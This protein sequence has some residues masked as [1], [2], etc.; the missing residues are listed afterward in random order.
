MWEKLN[1]DVCLLGGLWVKCGCIMCGDWFVYWYVFMLRIY[2]IGMVSDIVCI[3]VLYYFVFWYLF[4]IVLVFVIF[5]E[6]CFFWWKIEI[7]FG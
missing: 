3:V 5:G 1:V 6:C 2:C 4:Y 7:F